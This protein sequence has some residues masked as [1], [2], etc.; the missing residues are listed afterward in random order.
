[1]TEW[2]LFDQGT[3]PAFCTN[4]FFNRHPWVP[5]TDQVGHAERIHLVADMVKSHLGAARTLSDLGCGDGSLLKLIRD[6]PLRMWGYDAGRE[7]VTRG[8]SDGL[9]V[10]CAD[11]L[12]DKVDLGDIVVMSEVLEHLIDPHGLLDTIAA[13]RMV[14]SSPASETNEWHYEHH[15]WCWDMD[16]YRA[17]FEDA[18]W[19]VLDQRAVFGGVAHHNDR[20]AELWF[21]ALVAQR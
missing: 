1:M 9:D 4:E 6:L 15:A 10:H 14:A 7:N 5:P 11:F 17:L 16:G 2:R 12:T 20:D 8:R 3:V 13:D 18:G 19:T 21:Q